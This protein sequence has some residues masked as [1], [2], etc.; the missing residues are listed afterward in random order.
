MKFERIGKSWGI[1]RSLW[2]WIVKD[3]D[4]DSDDEDLCDK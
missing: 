4:F 2:D 1:V 3:L